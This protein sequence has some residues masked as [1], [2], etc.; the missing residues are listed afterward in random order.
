MYQLWLPMLKAHLKLTHRVQWMRC[1]CRWNTPKLPL[2][3][4]N[5]NNLN[6]RP[7][8]VVNRSMP[9][10]FVAYKMGMAEAGAKAAPD[11]SDRLKKL[12]S[13]ENGYR[14]IFVSIKETSSSVISHPTTTPTGLKNLALPAQSNQ[15]MNK[16]H[17]TVTNIFLMMTNVLGLAARTAIGLKSNLIR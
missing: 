4:V 15:S 17:R 6:L 5:E 11:H 12:M 14:F 8:R 3:F 16:P 1:S 2:G 13:S 10:R 9:I 7:S